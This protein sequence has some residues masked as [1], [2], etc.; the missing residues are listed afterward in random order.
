MFQKQKRQYV[1]LDAEEYLLYRR[2]IQDDYADWNG[3]SC[4]VDGK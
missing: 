1:I 3:F 4:A 2:N